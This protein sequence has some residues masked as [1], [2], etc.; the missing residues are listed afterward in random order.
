VPAT[1]RSATKLFFMLE[2]LPRVPGLDRSNER[3]GPIRAWGSLAQRL[4]IR[5]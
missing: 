3:S 5:I 4:K 1:A 2:R